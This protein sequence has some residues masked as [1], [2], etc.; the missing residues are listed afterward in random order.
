MVTGMCWGAQLAVYGRVPGGEWEPGDRRIAF[1]IIVPQMPGSTSLRV[2]DFETPAFLT[3]ERGSFAELLSTS[4]PLHTSLP[5]PPA[6]IVIKGE[7]VR[8]P[9]KVSLV[10]RLTRSFSWSSSRSSA[11]HSSQS[12][13]LNG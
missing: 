4:I 1:S 7:P 10:S 2:I 12:S 6:H 3:K 5:L 8:V 11:S 9:R 13:S